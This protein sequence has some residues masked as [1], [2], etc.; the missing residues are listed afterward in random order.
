MIERRASR[1]R[2]LGFKTQSAMHRSPAQP[3]ESGSASEAV[4]G[5]CRDP[6]LMLTVGV[7]LALFGLL[8]WH[9]LFFWEVN[10]QYSYGWVVPGLAI[11]LFLRRWESRP[12]PQISPRWAGLAL[13]VSLFVLAPLW[14]VREATPDWSVVSWLFALTVVG[15]LLVVLCR[16]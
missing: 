11:Y 5:F 4:G 8:I 16:L 7:L 2:S 12:R 14:L 9:L 1:V 6:A 13:V 3:G 10:P 15:S